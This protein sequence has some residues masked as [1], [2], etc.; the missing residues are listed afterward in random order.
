M[1]IGFSTS[2]NSSAS[3]NPSASINPS[4]SGLMTPSKSAKFDLMASFLTVY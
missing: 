1:T 3:A 2:A 4:V